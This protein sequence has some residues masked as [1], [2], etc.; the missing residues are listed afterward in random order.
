MAEPG[1][2]APITLARGVVGQQHVADALAAQQAPIVGVLDLAAPGRAEQR[3]GGQA[4]DPVRML[5]V[6]LEPRLP[7]PART[8]PALSEGSARLIAR[9]ASSSESE[10]SSSS[11]PADGK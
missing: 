6:A 10:P 1:L 4:D 7:D 2:E 9:R 8:Q 5:G 3:P 11:G